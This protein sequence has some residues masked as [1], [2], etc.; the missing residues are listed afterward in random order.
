[1]SDQLLERV[2][3][4]EP[5]AV[6][7][8]IARY[9][10]L[11]WS[12]ARRFCPNRADAEDAVQDIFIELWRSAGRY[13]KTLSA[14]STFVG[15]IARRE[16]IDRYRTRMRRRDTTTG[17]Q[18]DVRAPSSTPPLEIR[19]EAARA[20]RLS[21]H[22]AGKERLVIALAVERGMTQAGIAR[23]TGISVGS[24]KSHSRRGLRKLR[25]MLDTGGDPTMRRWSR[26]SPEPGNRPGS[27]A[28][29]AN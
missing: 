25:W 16:L 10:G 27:D 23:Y 7:E 1:M 28:R 6:N 21:D 24:V 8:C 11:V 15:V 2:A 5:G 18:G 13:D 12:L 20:A 19:E 14:E 26:S 3:R 4:N 9:E 22:L 29:P 17:D